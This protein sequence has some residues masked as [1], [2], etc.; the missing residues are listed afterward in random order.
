MHK[1][2]PR[3]RTR[4]REEAALRA[5]I[6]DALG[7]A[8]V[9]SDR[10][11]RIIY[12]NQAA[13]AL[14]GWSGSEA[15]GGDVAAMLAADGSRGDA[16]AILRHVRAGETWAGD[17]FVKDRNG[18]AFPIQATTTPVRDDRGEIVGMVGVAR[19]QSAQHEAA[20]VL[21][22]TEE[23]LELVHRATASVIW[24]WDLRT[25]ELRWNDAIGDAFGYPPDAV[26]GTV[27]WWEER[28][29][30][31]DRERVR[32]GL[33][34]ALAEGR[35]FWTEEY[36]FLC[37]NGSYALVFDRAYVALDGDGA[38][39]RV[40]GTMLD[41]T[42]RRRAHDA[43]R[44]LSQAGML[45]DL[46]LD[47]EA[48]L[49][50]LARLA[51]QTV[52]DGCLLL[53]ATGDRVEQVVAA[54]RDPERQGAL[55]RVAARLFASGLRGTITERV[56]RH[57]KSVALPELSP[58][59]LE[60]ADMDEELR[61][62]AQDAGL[63]GLV[64]A[65]MTARG[66]TVG[67]VLLGRMPGSPRQGEEDVRV[68]E[69][70]GRRVGLAVDH[71]RL[72]QSAEVARRAKTDFLSVIS[73]ELR[74]PL[75]AVMGYADL[76]AAQIAG[77]LNRAQGQ[78]VERIQAGAQKLLQA[79]E[80]ILAYARLETGRERPQLERVRLDRLLGRVRDVVGSKATERGVSFEEDLSAAPA[81]VCVDVEKAAHVLLALLT[82]A[83]KFCGDGGRCGLRVAEE[84]D[85]L[86][87]DIT[88]SGPGV[89]PEHLPHLFSPFWQAEQPEVRRSSGSGLGLT[90]ARRFA[91]LMAGDVALL[92]TSDAGTTFRFTMPLE[93]V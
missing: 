46:S 24:E 15:I 66:E 7:D 20:E 43:A 9:A 78:Q 49:P 63:S 2:A 72:F 61:A 90:L 56:L 76:L 40:V 54:A 59:L 5:A 47:Y 22:E 93:P 50:S 4:P 58:A 86:V 65:P 25:R 26:D 21:R 70:L 84:G 75:T 73:H 77:K 39:V 80:A 14:F 45:L 60:G 41:L 17:F 44:F 91:R 55:D 36:R 71:A 85:Q 31:E 57:G 33:A 35:R 87:F 34:M 10:D 52:A 51:A 74:T 6:L 8:V 23:R 89:A 38:P 68:A 29:H 27:L 82:N 37:G 13:Q 67:A 79:I 12:W 88:D 53:I 30:A 64:L 83:L 69:E 18:R 16:V 62:A 28:V 3:P 48:T 19:D 1:V 81:F 11:G 32:D 42:E 92:T